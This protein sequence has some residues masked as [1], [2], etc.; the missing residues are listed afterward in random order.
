MVLP[1]VDRGRLMVMSAA[2]AAMLELAKRLTPEERGE[3]RAA[4]ETMADDDPEWTATIRRRVAE[5]RSGAV[6]GRPAD[7]VAAEIRVKLAQSRGR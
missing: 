4:L 5:A 6:A 3:L 7:E 2:V 1:R